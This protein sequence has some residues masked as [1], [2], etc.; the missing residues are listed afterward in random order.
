MFRACGSSVMDI[1]IHVRH[2]QSIKHTQRACSCAL[3]I[4]D[5]V[6][7]SRPRGGSHRDYH[8]TPYAFE[9]EQ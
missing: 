2:R 4:H 1:C 7:G 9:R 5:R 3:R 8:W 6:Q